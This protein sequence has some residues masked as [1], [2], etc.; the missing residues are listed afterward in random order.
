[1]QPI[2]TSR[3]TEDRVER[4]QEADRRRELQLESARRQ[5]VPGSR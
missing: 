5:D 3:P 4:D 2:D 1:M